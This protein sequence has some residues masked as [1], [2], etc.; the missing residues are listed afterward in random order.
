MRKNN[1]ISKDSL[2]LFCVFSINERKDEC[3]FEKLVK[4]CF[5]CF[6]EVFS[7]GSY[8][9]PDSRKLDRPLRYLRNKNFLK[10]N[11]KK[12]FNLT[13]KGIKKAEEV[14]NILRQEKLKI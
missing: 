4:E 7:L 13:K 6:P 2:I 9:W 5:N 3:S 8:S 11:S 12:E 14:I 1:K 10:S